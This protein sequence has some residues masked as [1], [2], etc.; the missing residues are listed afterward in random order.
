MTWTRIARRKR[1][2]TCLQINS[3]GIHPSGGCFLCHPPHAAVTN[4]KRQHV[5]CHAYS[6]CISLHF[7]LLIPQLTSFLQNEAW[8]VPDPF[9]TQEPPV[10]ADAPSDCHQFHS[11]TEDNKQRT[12]HETNRLF[13]FCALKSSSESRFDP[14]PSFL[15]RHQCIADSRPRIFCCLHVPQCLMKDAFSHMLTSAHSQSLETYWSRGSAPYGQL[16]CV[17]PDAVGMLVDANRC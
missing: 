3:S 11:E 5:S 7:L 4:W 10:G 6:L 1:G 16:T 13:W 8:N 17:T 12:F 2:N 9:K 14:F 15:V